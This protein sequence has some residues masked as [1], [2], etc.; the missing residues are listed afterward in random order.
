MRPLSSTTQTELTKMAS[1]SKTS[2]GLQELVA[3][4]CHSLALLIIALP[5]TGPPHYPRGMLTTNWEPLNRVLHA[6]SLVDYPDRT[7]K[8]ASR[9]KTSGLQNW[10]EGTPRCTPYNSIT[11]YWD[12]VPEGMLTRWESDLARYS[13]EL[14]C[15]QTHE[16]TNKSTVNPLSNL[17]QITHRSQFRRKDY[18]PNFTYLT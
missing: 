14:K 2:S 9:S 6:T 13:S 5:L 11:P 7:K 4:G 18:L 15:S 17:S 16:H 1:R 8:M 3:K 10:C 12:L